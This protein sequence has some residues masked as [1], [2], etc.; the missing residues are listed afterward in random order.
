M[1]W[2]RPE[3]AQL[4][5]CTCMS[6]L[7]RDATKIFENFDTFQLALPLKE[8]FFILLNWP[9]SYEC[10]CYIYGHYSKLTIDLSINKQETFCFNSPRQLRI[11]KI[12]LFYT[13]RPPFILDSLTSPSE[14]SSLQLCSFITISTLFPGNRINFP[15]NF[16]LRK[17]S[18]EIFNFTF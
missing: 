11:I 8:I 6:L 18:C 2:S 10:Q 5:H 4:S 9:K 7:Q 1:Y 16:D 14:K 3:Q 15:E 17:F 12:F 13:S